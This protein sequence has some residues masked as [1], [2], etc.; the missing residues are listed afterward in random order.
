[1]PRCVALGTWMNAGS[2]LWLKGRGSRLE[3]RFDFGHAGCMTLLDIQAAM[4]LGEYNGFLGFWFFS[5]LEVWPG[6]C[7]ESKVQEEET[8]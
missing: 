4:H 1:M 6:S 7:T 3:E 2:R 5:Y 8:S